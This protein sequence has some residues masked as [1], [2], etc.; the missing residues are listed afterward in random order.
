MSCRMQ[1]LALHRW[2]ADIKLMGS[3]PAER[4]EKWSGMK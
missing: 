1:T 4:T 3:L 2:K